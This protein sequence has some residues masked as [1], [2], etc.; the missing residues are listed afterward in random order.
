VSDQDLLDVVR[1]SFADVHSRTPARVIVTRGRAIRA[2]RKVMA[3]AVSAA[4]TAIAA[5]LIVAAAAPAGP[6]STSTSAKA[7]R[8]QPSHA[9]L[10]AWTVTA[11]RSGLLKITVREMRDPRGLQANLRA[12]GA[13][14]VVTGSLAAPSTCRQWKGGHYRMGPRL[15]QMASRSGLPSRHGLEML[16]RPSA[17]PSGAA[18]WMGIGGIPGPAGFGYV[19]A[20]TACLR[21]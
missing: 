14:V 13:R 3:A 20:T 8:H 16:L 10:A 5:V 15:I 12:A 4:V 18:L 19:R 11:M 6:P 2:H 21:S 9:K 1:D 17:I 7:S